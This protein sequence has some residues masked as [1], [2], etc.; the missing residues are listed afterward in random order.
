[1]KA[2][3]S[4]LIVGA[5]LAGS[6]CAETLR[7]EGYDGRVVVV[8]DEPMPPYERPAL[9]K[10]FLAGERPAGS[11]ALRP[12]SFWAEH[13]IELVLGRRVVTVDR[14]SRVAR[15]DRG[16]AIEWGALVLATGARARRLPF[17]SPPGVHVL[18]T[19]ADATALRAELMPGR[20]LA[21]VGG[22]FVGSEVA[23]TARGLGVEV[24]MLEAGPAPFAGL[25][26]ARVGSA[27]ALRYREH[28]VDLRTNTQAAA[29][30]T[31][32]SGRL[33]AVVLDDGSEVACD[34][35]LVAI[36]VEAE[37]GLRAGQ[38]VP[39][40]H[41]CGD[42]AGGAGHWTSAAASAA[43]T[44]RVLLGLKPLPP[45]P[46]FFWS[47]QFGLRLQLVGSPRGSTVVELDGSGERFTAR[48]RA[49]NGRLVAALTANRPE[50]IASLRR[51]LALAA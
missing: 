45:A 2:P 34:A 6:R 50:E 48:Y 41:V 37:T 26:G 47:D 46:S 11:L 29:F 24:T 44:A 36:G 5:G 35:A 8:G 21:V 20:R 31:V 3:R 15:T 19:A 17:A 32:P 9:S 12:D 49:A 18:R 38:A 42:A 39:P 10:E 22:G 25:L 7:H 14:R 4:V 40:V 43:S 33:R 27:L 23:S 13:E 28:G 16:D 51:E 30:S 1:V